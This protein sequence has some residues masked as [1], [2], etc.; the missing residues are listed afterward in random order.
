M[1]FIGPRPTKIQHPFSGRLICTFL[2]TSLIC[3]SKRTKWTQGCVH[4]LCP[5]VWYTINENVHKCSF[6]REKCSRVV[7]AQWICF[8]ETNKR[9]HCFEFATHKPSR[10]PSLTDRNRGGCMSRKWRGKGAVEEHT[11]FSARGPL[12]H[13]TLCTIPIYRSSQQQQYG[14]HSATASLLLT[15][16]SLSPSLSLLPSLSRH[17]DI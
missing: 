11:C 8:V 4:P 1:P 14:S 15:A 10:A 2:K 5:L 16:F 6:I 12:P 9:R 7:H 3:H 17:S 13:K